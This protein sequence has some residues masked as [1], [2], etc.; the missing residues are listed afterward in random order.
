MFI[1]QI[2]S[3]PHLLHPTNSYRAVWP[4]VALV[5]FEHQS[6]A[7]KALNASE[8]QLTVDLQTPWR[9][10][11]VSPAVETVISNVHRSMGT[12]KERNRDIK[13][14][15]RGDDYQSESVAKE[16]KRSLS[17][18]LCG[19]ARLT[20]DGIYHVLK[21]L[22]LRDLTS[23]ELVCRKWNAIVHGVWL[24]WKYLFIDI[25]ALRSTC[26]LFNG[27]LYYI[28]KKCP[29]LKIFEM[30]WQYQLD[31]L[32]IEI[33]GKCCPLLEKLVFG[34]LNEISPEYLAKCCPRLKVFN[35]RVRKH[36][37]LAA[38]KLSN[39]SDHSAI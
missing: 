3:L 35:F 14:N 28:L 4:R 5:T 19:I 39:F 32:S 8:E 36:N 2:N 24:S 26:I 13:M 9:V 16:T 22:D 1:L 33:I 25:W 31:E 29:N 34:N 27:Y 7:L 15:E 11:R 23:C 6:S 30:E 20:N 38:R 17:P 21:W 37:Y 18:E 10:L 12:P